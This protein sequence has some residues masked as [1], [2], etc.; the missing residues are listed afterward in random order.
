M[1][2]NMPPR[3]TVVVDC[4]HVQCTYVPVAFTEYS[5]NPNPPHLRASPTNQ[6]VVPWRQRRWMSIRA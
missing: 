4:S 3:Q 5:D 2:A 6:H 1:S